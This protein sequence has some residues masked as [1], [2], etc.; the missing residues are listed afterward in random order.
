MKI[1]IESIAFVCGVVVFCLGLLITCLMVGDH[2]ESLIARLWPPDVAWI[3]WALIG[4]FV[5]NTV[6][7]KGLKA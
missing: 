4:Y 2:Q 3:G 5:R 1:R 6:R 7:A